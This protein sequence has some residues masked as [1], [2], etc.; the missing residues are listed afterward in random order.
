MILINRDPTSII[1]KEIISLVKSSGIPR[2][3]RRNFIQISLCELPKIHRYIEN[4]SYVVPTYYFDEEYRGIMYRD[5]SVRIR[6]HFHI[7][8]M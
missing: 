7:K 3:I 8:F 4:V 1:K 2:E 6:K 5:E